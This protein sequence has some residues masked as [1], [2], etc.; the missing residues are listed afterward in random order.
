MVLL[1]YGKILLIEVNTRAGKT[2]GSSFWESSS[3]GVRDTEVWLYF[4]Q[5]E[6]AVL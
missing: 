3:L 4:E 6:Q 1:F 2:C 5:A